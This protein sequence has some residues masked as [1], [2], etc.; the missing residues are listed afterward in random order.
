MSSQMNDMMALLE[1]LKSEN[2]LDILK[3]ELTQERL[4]EA[5][6]ELLMRCAATRAFDEPLMDSEIRRHVPNGDKKCVPFD[7]FVEH[8]EIEQMLGLEATYRVRRIFRETLFANWWTAPPVPQTQIPP[9]LAAFSKRLATYYKRL[10]K[11]GEDDHLYHLLIADPVAAEVLFQKQYKEADAAFDMGRC[12]DLLAILEGRHIFSSELTALYVD[13]SIYRKARS[14]W[15]NEYD[16]STIY[17]QRKT[18]SSAVQKLL[19]GAESK[20]PEVR[21][22][23]SLHAQGGLGK[24][25]LIRWLI[26]RY[27]VPEPRRI[28]CVLLDFDRSDHYKITKYPWRIF[29]HLAE[30]LNVQLPQDPFL[31]QLRDMI[32]RIN[33][34]EVEE[35][36]ADKPV[37]ENRS[38]Q[39][40]LKVKAASHQSAW[41]EPMERFAAVLSS[42]Q[43][44][45]SIVIVLDTLEQILLR[46]P[47]DLRTVLEPLIALRDA[48]PHIALVLSGRNSLKDKTPDI[49]KW[50]RPWMRTVAVRPFSN[51]EARAYLTEKR[52][53]PKSDV[54]D[55]AILVCHGNPFKLTLLAELL[56][57]NP[58]MTAAEVRHYSDIDVAYLVLRVVERIDNPQVRWVLRYGVVP[59][60]LTHA[61]FK[62]IMVPYLPAAITGTSPH[63]DPRQDNLPEAKRDNTFPILSADIAPAQLDLDALWKALKLYAGQYSWVQPAENDPE[64]LVF[65]PDVRHA[66]RRLLQDQDIFTILNRDAAAYYE[67]QAKAGA[68]PWAQ[69]MCEAVY[70]HFQ[71]Q[72]P[73]ADTT[74][75]SAIEAAKKRPQADAVRA[76]ARE[77]SG[78]EYVDEWG[79]PLKRTDGRELL[80]LQ[81][82]RDAN[83]YLSQSW[84]GLTAFVQEQDD[85]TDSSR[86]WKEAG[87][88]FRRAEKLAKQIG[89][90][91]QIPEVERARLRAMLLLHNDQYAAVQKETER[92]SN[93]KQQGPNIVSLSASE[94]GLMMVQAEALARSGKREEAISAYA[95]LEKRSQTRALRELSVVVRQRLMSLYM[96]QGGY[97]SALSVAIRA[98]TKT[99]STTVT[100]PVL[101][102]I[103]RGLVEAALKQ[104]QFQSART[105][106]DALLESGDAKSPASTDESVEIARR[107]L[108]SAR[109]SLAMLDAPATQQTAAQLEQ[110]LAPLLETL[111]SN[112]RHELIAARLEA[113]GQA[114]TQL[115]S[116]SL[117]LTSLEQ[118]RSHYQAQGSIPGTTRCLLHL[119]R[120]YE[121]EIGDMERFGAHLSEAER[122]GSGAEPFSAADLDERTTELSVRLLE[123][124]RL[125]QTSTRS[126]A[127]AVVDALLALPRI[128]ETPRLSVQAALHG[129]LLSYTPIVTSLPSALPT[130][131][132]AGRRYLASLLEALENIQSPAERLT[133]LGSLRNSPTLPSPNETNAPPEA[134]PGAERL[135]ALAGDYT[136][137]LPLPLAL[138]YVEILRCCGQLDR[139][140][141]LL[142]A[143]EK[144]R[145]FGTNPVVLSRWLAAQNRLQTGVVSRMT[146]PDL[147][148][149]VEPLIPYSMLYGTAS[150]DILPF[151][152]SSDRQTLDLTR[153][154]EEAL[155]SEKR[156]NQWQVRAALARA[157]MA[158]QRRQYSNAV[159]ALQRAREGANALNNTFLTVE[160]DALA[161]AAER[162]LP[163]ANDDVPDP[164]LSQT[165]RMPF[166]AMRFL[167]G[168]DRSTGGLQ[169][170]SRMPGPSS[171]RFHAIQYQG[172][173]VRLL[174]E[175]AGRSEIPTSLTQRYYSDLEGTLREMRRLLTPPAEEFADRLQEAEGLANLQPDIRFEIEGEL[176]AA[177][178][179]E[180]MVLPSPEQPAGVT[181]LRY[182]YRG[183]PGATRPVPIPRQ[184]HSVLLLHSD[185]ERRR[186]L[187]ER[188]RFAGMEVNVVSDPTSAGIVAALQDMSPTII[189]IVASMRESPSRGIYLDFGDPTE[190]IRQI[191]Y[192]KTRSVDPDVF[193]ASYLSLLLNEATPRS[194]SL[195][196]LD[197][198]PPPHPT[199]LI[200]QLL[201]RNAFASTLFGALNG[202]HILGMGLAISNLR[203]ALPDQLIHGLINGQSIGDLTVAMRSLK[204]VETTTP[205]PVELCATAGVALF[206]EDPGTPIFGP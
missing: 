34:E 22:I 121:G 192:T 113:E 95:R 92:W 33:I 14:Y 47:A 149:K 26:S 103:Q 143:L 3:A 58:N 23:L 164:L 54:T 11:S 93:T 56:R 185:M 177:L 190:S 178:P 154:A 128:Q 13:R 181:N 159:E 180:M 131:P 76:L 1:K 139:A 21:W 4:P 136:E 153:D 186:M 89:E 170:E 184:Q 98:I 203:V 110:L 201:L 174:V 61:F 42:Q 129:L 179:W 2:G 168:L 175:S 85:N 106:A 166:P 70:H 157:R 104:G 194:F 87:D 142:D 12:I 29:Y 109:V 39:A 183:F 126:A 195:I 101:N 18:L 94:A 119:L 162:A 52:G 91:E 59:R 31:P 100:N 81:T 115:R 28:P 50:L 82:L 118:A 75:R 19:V 30:Q 60:Y 46:P 172:E 7:Q 77:V 130:D 15:V 6:Q 40:T 204:A 36:S 155:Q 16:R 114:H 107:L 53:L 144:R 124:T 140:R 69:A 133:L 188:Y 125:A 189:H 161:T 152:R 163:I 79:V 68:M 83:Y 63:D 45:K 146:G 132:E 206:T 96:Q 64:T 156:I 35:Q 105:K 158:L 97:F 187:E 57:T 196:V 182:L 73:A 197:I 88:A 200:R 48:Y 20:D 123:A 169:V 32:E 202:E 44:G 66:M 193:S 120:L 205:T 9:K 72:G 78:P 137:E 148:K 191:Q 111:P 147:R 122:L 27:C 49:E 116:Y 134:L 74:W 127:L 112:L 37:V 65:H 62:K 117:A 102:I 108:I 90:S 176:V 171:P 51:P 167:A 135:I 84:L 10:G 67:Q 8:N 80:S 138:T 145:D 41:Q 86:N 199:E 5:E 55:A 160:A 38:T 25:A 151:Y 150:L 165:D 71:W 198:L 99:L 17:Y 43:H 24:T 141:A 173:L